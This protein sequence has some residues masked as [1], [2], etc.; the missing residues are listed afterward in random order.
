MDWKKKMQDGLNQ[1]LDSSK[2]LFQDAKKQATKLG[3]QSVL[4]LE[5]KQLESKE[6]ELIS[7]L[8]ERV[9]QL[10]VQEGQSTVSSRSSGVKD[11]LDEIQETRTMLEEKRI[12]RKQEQEAE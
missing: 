2:K 4:A 11:I 5:I 8:G 7:K 1:G 10:L 6:E 3:E 9:Y 12:S